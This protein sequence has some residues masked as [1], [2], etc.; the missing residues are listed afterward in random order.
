MNQHNNDGVW[1]PPTF[2]AQSTAGRYWS[3]LGKR[4]QALGFQCA[5]R[6]DEA[7]RVV[8]VKF[9]PITDRTCQVVR[10]QSDGGDAMIV[11]AT[12]RES[13]VPGDCVIECVRKGL[14]ELREIL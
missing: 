7:E 14:E 8:E 12:Y 3:E 10:E 6:L 13:D 11:A 5:V 2:E 1:L 9:S 4:I